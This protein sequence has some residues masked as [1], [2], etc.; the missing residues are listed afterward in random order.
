MKFKLLFR[1]FLPVFLVVSGLQ[2]CTETTI[3]LDPAISYQTMTGWEVV[4]QAGQEEAI[5]AFEAVRDSLFTRAA[6]EVGINRLRLEITSGTENPV[7]HFALFLEGKI[8]FRQFHKTMYQVVN[9]NDDP[10]SINPDGFGFTRLDNT[11]DKVVL[12]LKQVIEANGEH[13][14]INLNY[15]DFKTS[16]F[17][18]TQDIEEYAEFMLATFQHIDA[19]YGWVPDAIEVILEPDNTEN[20]NSGEVIGKA[21]VATAKRLQTHGY[22]PHFIAPSTTSAARASRYFDDMVSVADV[23]PYLSEIS[24]HRY[25][26]VSSKS[27]QDI[28]ERAE[29]YSLATSMLEWWESGNTYETLYVDVALVNNSAWQRGTLAWPLSDYK[30]PTTLYYIDINTHPDK[31]G[32]LMTPQTRFLRQYFRFIR[33]GAVRYKAVSSNPAFGPLAFRNTNGTQVLVIKASRGGSFYLRGLPEG[34]YGVRYTT[35]DK[36]GVDL[37]DMSVTSGKDLEAGIPA[38]GVITFYS[39][40]LA[41][42]GAGVP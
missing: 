27:L 28:A 18:H 11:I 20:W 6:N 33:L 30:D 14:Y 26:G 32:L 4:A 41:G 12:P 25:A 13:L 36:D 5:P 7:D 17:E 37:P 16:P 29:R 15:V 38:A 2:A 35:R 23:L 9:D 10:F 21:I 39:K 34:V 31:P 8:S 40:S 22:R 3:T 1:F 19:R 24:Y 42:P